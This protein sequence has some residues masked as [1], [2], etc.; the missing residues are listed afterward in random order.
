MRFDANHVLKR[1]PKAREPLPEAYREIYSA[2]YLRNR[3]GKT[4][5]TSLSMKLERWLHHAVAA[6]VMN[7]DLDVP[8]LEI[9]AGTLNQL[10]YEPGIRTYDIVEP[11]VELYRHSPHLSRIRNKYLD[12]SE[13]TENRYRRITSVAVFEHIE[14]LPAVVTRAARLLE[15][16]GAMRISIPN[17]GTFLWRLGTYITGHEYKKMYGLDYQ[18][19]MRFEHLNT[20]DEIEAVMR[21]FFRK[22]RVKFFGIH[23]K[24]AL[25]R[26]LECKEPIPERAKMS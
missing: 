14:D 4:Q 10:P 6:D 24:V 16:G 7:S 17:E 12:I 8:T 25:Y 2:H 9:G 23:K 19:L 26:F 5:A 22:V 18:V 3:E 21:Y 20:A 15:P 13:I 11:F 1:F